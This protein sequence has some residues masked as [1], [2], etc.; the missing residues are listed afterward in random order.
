LVA[1][2]TRASVAELG[3]HPGSEVRAHLK[4]AALQ[5]FRAAEE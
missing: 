2:I 1:I 4:A 5:A 3:L